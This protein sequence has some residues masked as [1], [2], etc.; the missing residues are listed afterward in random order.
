MT[1]SCY[2]AQHVVV[3]F[4]LRRAW[5]KL[6]DMTREEAQKELVSL[7]HDVAPHLKDYALE[8]W[9]VRKLEIGNVE[10]T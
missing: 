2:I 9:R 10:K 1:I 7:L 3:T 6:G 5:M 4:P 8:Q